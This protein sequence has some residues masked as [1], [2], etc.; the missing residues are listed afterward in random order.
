LPAIYLALTNFHPEMIPTDL[1]L[2]IA[3]SREKVPFP[4][5]VEVLI[6]EISIELIREAGVRIPGVIGPT[7]GIVGALILGQA[8][9]AASIVSPILVV[10]VAITALGAFAV[11]N[12]G[13]AF[14][15]R[16][17]RFVYIVLAAALGFYGVA[18]GV[19]IQLVTYVNLKSFGVPYM[20]PVAPHTRSSGDALFRFPVWKSEIRPSFLKPQQEERQPRISRGWV[21]NQDKSGGGNT[22]STNSGRKTDKAKAKEVKGE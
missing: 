4:T 20:S 6:M 8:A 3:A 12:F 14:A 17:Y 1:L 19:F 22:P 10:I 7:L 16:L 9:V 18:I 2:A 15:I 13:M 21:V 5:A 11:P